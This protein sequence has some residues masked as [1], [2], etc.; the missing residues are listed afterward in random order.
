[1]NRQLHD[2]VDR[3]SQYRLILLSILV[4]AFSGITVV[5]YRLALEFAE[6]IS[7]AVFSLPRTWLTIVLIFAGLLLLG[8]VTGLITKSEPMIRGSGIPQAE[9]QLLGFFDMCWW[10]VLIKKFVGGFLC[11]LGG[12]SLG[13]EGPSIQLGT[14]AGL[15]VSRGLKRDRLEEKYLM[16][17]G[18]C[19]GLAAA[20]NAPLAGVV[21]ALE[22]LHKSFSPK[23]LLCAL[24]SA[25]TGDLV[26]AAF[27]GTSTVFDLAPV[28]LLP[29]SYYLLLGIIGA[30]LGLFGVLYNKILMNSLRLYDK[31]RLPL[32]LRM[33]IPFAIAGVA[34]L[35]LPE[36]LFGGHGIIEGLTAGKYALE[37][38]CLLLAAKFLFSMASFGSGA[39]GGIFFPLLVLGALA[40][41]IMGDVVIGLGFVPE[42]YRTNFIL[43]GMAG[44]F[45]AIVRAPLTGIILVVEM[46]GSFSQLL[47][48]TVV[49]A[50]AYIVANACHSTPVYDSLL[51]RIIPEPVRGADDGILY[52]FTLQVGSAAENQSIRSIHWPEGCLVVSVSRG[53][54]SFVPQ[55]A[56]VLRPADRVTV[57]CGKRSASLHGQLAGLFS[58]KDE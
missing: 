37:F 26:S 45:S 10:Q 34:G 43:L 54:E 8:F 57:M 51:K 40:G 7:L 42:L 36:I 23:V 33:M 53:S 31:I 38:M 46:S 32:Q 4:G 22:E 28:T 50:V 55:G 41:A 49:S 35:F 24:V 39:P 47:G 2:L 48:L 25:I 56:M 19:A 30:V 14:M 29:P 1:M 58:V 15:G 3:H 18:A 13:R 11:I 20:F 12:L 9:G 27:F 6:N 16:T 21:F 17:C 44:M 52:E 5:A